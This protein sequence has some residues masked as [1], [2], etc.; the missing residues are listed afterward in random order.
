M[1]GAVKA[2]EICGLVLDVLGFVL[3][4]GSSKCVMPR[5]NDAI[6]RFH[7]TNMESYI[8]LRLVSDVIVVRLHG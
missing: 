5:I 6:D 7:R 2:L 1:V 4:S 3:H 8:E